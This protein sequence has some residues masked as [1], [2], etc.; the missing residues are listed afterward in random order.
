MTKVH[1]IG[2]R[3][4]LQEPSPP[5]TARMVTVLIAEDDSQLRGVLAALI[6][7]EPM[8]QL[9]AA[10]RDADEAIELARET[11]PDVAIVDVRMPGGGGVKVARELRRSTPDTKVLALTAAADRSTVLEMLEAGV[12]GY[13]VKGSSPE[14]ILESIGRAGSGQSMLSAEVTGDVISELVGQLGNQRR[15]EERERRRRGRIE[16]VIADEGA[17]QVVFQP[18]CAL[19]TLEPRGFEALARFPGAPQRGPE[20]WFREATEVGLGIQLELV[21][22]ER[23]LAHLA[24]LPDG[25]YMSVNV[26]PDTVVSTAFK[27]VLAAVPAERVVVEITEHAPIDDYDAFNAGLGS[28]RALGARLAID[29]AGAGFASLR[30]ILRLEPELI[31]LDITLIA[32]IE[33]D[34]SQQALAAGIISFAE[35]IGATVVAEGIEHAEALEALRALGVPFGQGFQLGRPAGLK[36]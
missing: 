13:L 35:G 15:G 5:D 3:T 34:R 14:H 17:V 20:H 16:R 24:E 7:S 11:R 19:D 12:V 29:D 1:P 26:S 8:L 30:H 21:S 4:L 33:S 25:A 10:A 28:V 9:V 6:D 27:R 2:G 18:I 32:A 23:A 36:R 22:V 31:K